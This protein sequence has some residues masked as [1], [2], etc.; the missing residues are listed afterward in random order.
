MNIIEALNEVRDGNTVTRINWFDN[1][2][3]MLS[4]ETGKIVVHNTC[5]NEDLDYLFTADDVQAD[6]WVIKHYRRP[7]TFVDAF[8]E[9]KNGKKV[10]RKVWNDDCYITGDTRLNSFFLGEEDLLANDW[11]VIEA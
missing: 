1:I 2:V 6:N 4:S 3:V 8:K 11:E 10:R 9:V 7:L 5:T